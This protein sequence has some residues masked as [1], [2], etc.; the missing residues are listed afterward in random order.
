MTSWHGL[1]TAEYDEINR[2]AIKSRPVKG[3]IKDALSEATYQLHYS[4]FKEEFILEGHDGQGNTTYYAPKLDPNGTAYWSRIP[5][6]SRGPV[7]GVASQF[8]GTYAQVSAHAQ[9]LNKAEAERT[10]GPVHIYS[11]ELVTAKPV[12]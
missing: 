12:A 7:T 3:P 1:N 11:V 4:P 5:E 10:G 9:R 6:V 2:Q 8:S